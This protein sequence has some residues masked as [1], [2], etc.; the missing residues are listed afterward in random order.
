MRANVLVNGLLFVGGFEFFFGEYIAIV[1]NF[2]LSRVDGHN[3]AKIEILE[4]H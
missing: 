4:G 2:V 1:Y 3:G